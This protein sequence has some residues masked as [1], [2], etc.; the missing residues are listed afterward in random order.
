MGYSNLKV[1]IL[2]HKGI[3]GHIVKEYFDS[4]GIRVSII[5]GRWP[6]PK[7]KNSI[8]ES[9]C[10]V[11]INCAAAIPQNHK[12][13]FKINYELPEFLAKNINVKIVHPASN[14]EDFL[15]QNSSYTQSKRAGSRITK[16]LAKDFLIIKSSI[17]GPSLNGNYGFWDF[18]SNADVQIFGYTDS[19]WNGITSL[20]WAKIALAYIKLDQ[21]GEITV[22]S[23]KNISKFDLAEI[24]ADEL[25]KDINILPDS[26]VKNNFCL[27]GKIITPN[28][29]Q[30]INDFI[31]WKKK[32]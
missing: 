21:K 5:E 4:L 27:E 26:S 12:K 32:S 10:D 6:D 30:Q 19:Y 3:L 11:I 29:R 28:I 22:I 18:V 14:I 9:K 8:L 16:S 25:G 20:E 1:L 24:L 23:P 13:S 31:Q 7:Y 2:G 15:E 17:I